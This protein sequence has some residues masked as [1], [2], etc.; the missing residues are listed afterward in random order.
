MSQLRL[1]VVSESKSAYGVA[2]EEP[3]ERNRPQTLDEALQVINKAMASEGAQL[4]ELLT[5]DY[6]NLRMAVEDLAPRV[7]EQVRIATAPYIETAR[8]VAGPQIDFAVQSGKTIA[9]EFDR[10]VKKNPYLVLGG[11][12]L[13][14]I[15]LGYLFGK[16][17]TE[18]VSEVSNNTGLSYGD[19][20]AVSPNA[21]LT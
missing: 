2:V 10:Q 16:K 17:R 11:V 19:V 4:K 13:G 7:K 8:D 3:M 21:E 14:A 20:P 9:T 6:E 1:A 5:S 18:P 12:A 15:A